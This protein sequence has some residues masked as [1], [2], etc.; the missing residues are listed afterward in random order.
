MAEWT[1][2]SA[3][4]LGEALERGRA[5]ARAVTEAFLDA[6]ACH[7]EAD[8]I[9]AR[10][11][12]ARARAE[13]A[14]S[15]DRARRGLRRGPLD[16]VPISLKD[17]FDTAGV[18]TEAGTRLLAGRVPEHDAA[19]VARLSR[20]GM[21]CLGKTHMTELAFSG[22]GINPV[23]ATPP[24]RHG[25]TLAPGGSS[26]GAAA[27]VAF[28]LAPIGLGSDTGGS[29]RAPAAWND[30]VGLK[31][32]AGLIPLDGAVPLSPTLDTVGPLCRTVGDAAL[33]LATLTETRPADL[34]GVSPSRL[35]LA[36]GTGALTERLAPAVAAAFED[37]LDRLARAGIAIER[38]AVPEAAEA[39]ATASSH[40]G[41]VN[42]EGYA[43][44]GD[45][46][47][48]EG[49]K[50]FPLIADRFR[51]GRG[52]RA[53]QIDHARLAFARLA[54]SY[55]ARLAPFDAMIAPTMPILPPRVEDLMTDPAS[56]AAA[57]MTCLRN[58]RVGN[59]L[60]L[61]GLT[62]PS[63]HAWCGLMLHGL[64]GEEARLLRIG[65]ALEM[66]LAD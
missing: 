58:T 2:S 40:G 47:E 51:S 8:R 18:A 3:A 46:I 20:A 19:C 15:A 11:M 37:A 45:R 41:I 33:A 61:C 30:L 1:D 39:L 49:D 28:G 64:P 6:I 4:E 36:V 34:S 59:L 21:V 66:A 27:S 52:F 55:R 42:T 24:N 32:T 26:S 57:N 50:M 31:T 10:T 54:K 14:A 22:L 56:L 53:D 12:P 23:T 17:L 65:R 25:R 7:P 35:R 48:A 9:Y 13:A 62:V 60:G 16:G 63:G 38:V 43:I 29:V 5:D 44:W